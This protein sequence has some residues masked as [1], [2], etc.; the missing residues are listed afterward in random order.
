MS[1]IDDR[2]AI[3]EMF[4]RYADALDRKDW[5]LFDGFF[6][7]D[8]VGSFTSQDPKMQPFEI[9]G[10]PALVEFAR[11]MIG[12]PEI[13][14]QHLMGNFSASI[15]GD[16]ATASVRMRNLHHGVGPREGLSQESIGHFAGR[17][18]RTEEGWRCEWW[19]EAMYVM[20]GDPALFAAEVA[21]DAER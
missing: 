13:V 9:D 18:V 17:F 1:E 16:R 21:A 15:D 8:C 20:L 6:T 14:T 12:S 5:S 3:N 11:Q 4:N 19:E 7:D 10:G 2:I